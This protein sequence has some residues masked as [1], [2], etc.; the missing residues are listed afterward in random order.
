MQ[1]TKL[2]IRKMR[3]LLLSIEKNLI[4]FKENQ[5]LLLV[6]YCCCCCRYYLHV[7]TIKV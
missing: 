7:I 1:I 3:M 6:S 5:P 4:F 2:K